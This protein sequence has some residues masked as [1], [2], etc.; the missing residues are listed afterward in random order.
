M[1][2]LI[3]QRVDP[4]SGLVLAEAMVLPPSDPVSDGHGHSLTEMWRVVLM[5]GKRQKER[6]Y[7]DK[8]QALDAA[9]RYVERGRT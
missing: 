1:T 7:A 4:T 9:V 8:W 5:E 2:R 3:V 6:V